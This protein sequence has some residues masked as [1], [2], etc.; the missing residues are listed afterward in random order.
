MSLYLTPTLGHR[1]GIVYRVAQVDAT[2]GCRSATFVASTNE[3]DVAQKSRRGL[4][5]QLT[6]PVTAGIC[7]LHSGHW[8]LWPTGNKV[9]LIS[10]RTISG[11]DHLQP[12]EVGPPWLTLAGAVSR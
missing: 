7:L 11:V 2:L 8:P 6:P 1:V 5:R 3:T 9:E 10:S 12:L 4:G